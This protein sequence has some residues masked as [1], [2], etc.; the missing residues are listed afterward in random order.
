MAASELY[1]KVGRPAGG[2]QGPP[3][4]RLR[5]GG[6]ARA[7]QRA[8]PRFRAFPNPRP[9][10][11]VARRRAFLFRAVMGMKAAEGGRPR[12]SVSAAPAGV[13]GREQSAFLGRGLVCIY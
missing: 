13:L 4:V 3:A 11:P 10:T 5:R 7:G 6:G 12:G 9:R 1:T 2:G 8:P